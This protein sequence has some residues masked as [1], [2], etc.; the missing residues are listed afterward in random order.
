VRVTL[1]GD[2][3]RGFEPGLPAASVRLLLPDPDRGWVLPTWNGNEFLDADGGRPL[4]RTL[5]PLHHDADANTLDVEIVRHGRAPLSARADRAAPGDRVALSGPGRGY[6]V[7]PTAPAF[8]LAGD[9]S[10]VPAITT[11][12]PVLPAAADVHVV[13]EIADP[14]ARLVLPT[15][16]RSTEQWC[17]SL[18]DAVSEVPLPPNTRVWVAGNAAVVQRV[19][20]HLFDERS[21]PRSHAVV[22]GYW[23]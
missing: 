12:V 14:S 3:L 2:E 16:P 22:R 17:A 20:K 8:V 19:R 21:V 18:A 6:D 23:K 7:D 5:T 11:L 4:L 15:H 1:A 10:A 13:V 9:E